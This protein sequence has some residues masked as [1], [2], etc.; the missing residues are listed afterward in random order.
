M[1]FDKSNV[2]NCFKFDFHHV[3]FVIMYRARWHYAINLRNVNG[4]TIHLRGD[5]RRIVKEW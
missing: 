1:Y 4:D 3:N 2:P 5:A